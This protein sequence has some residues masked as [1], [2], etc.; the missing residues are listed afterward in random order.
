MGTMLLFHVMNNRSRTQIIKTC[1]R[2]RK[3]IW[4]NRACI[5]G[6]TINNS[7]H[8]YTF[9]N[10]RIKQEGM[11]EE[12]EQN[13]K[14]K[15][16]NYY[17][18]IPF[19]ILAVVCYLYSDKSSARMIRTWYKTMFISYK[20]YQFFKKI[21]E[22]DPAQI[23]QFHKKCAEEALQCILENG[24]IFIKIGQTI[25]S[26]NHI[27]PIEWIQTFERCQDSVKY[28]HYNKISKVFYN[29]FGKMPTE[30][31]DEF[32]PV[33][34]ACASLA[35]VHRARLKETGEI[36]AVKIQYHGIKKRLS[37]DLFYLGMMRGV[38][39]RVCIFLTNYDDCY[40]IYI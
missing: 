8:Q 31:F 11:E 17:F 19:S 9:D 29:E 10:K 22:E 18:V 7:Y 38:L 5:H 33:P 21:E 35:Q 3:T 4:K 36:V 12:I 1:L 39:E 13:L 25:A 34:I 20:Y 32:E 14:I 2:A 28:Q 26:L 16:W 40:C 30:V 15:K 6:A 23:S 37:G 24:G 27:L